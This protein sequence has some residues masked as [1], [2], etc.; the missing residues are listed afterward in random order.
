MFRVLVVASI[1]SGFFPT[2]LFAQGGAMSVRGLETSGEGTAAWNASG[3]GPEPAATGHPVSWTSCVQNA[4]HYLATRDYVDAAASYGVRGLSIDA[5]FPLFSAALSAGGYTIADLTIAHGLLSLDDDIEGED[6]IYDAGTTLETRY[7][8]GSTTMQLFLG[9]E[10][11]ATASLTEIT[12]FIDY[13]TLS[14]CF[15]DQIFGFSEFVLP[16]DASAGSSAA[17]QNAAAA[18]IADVAEY[19]VRF[20]FDSIQP[21]AQLDFAGEG[22]SGAFFDVQGTYEQSDTPLPVEL[23]AFDALADGDAVSLRWATASETNNAGFEVQQWQAT[24]W[25]PLAWVGGYGTTIEPQSYGLMIP[26]L[27]PDQY[28]FRLKQIDFDGTFSF[29][30]VV[31]VHVTPAA[32]ASVSVFPNPAAASATL[33]LQWSREEPLTVALYDVQGREVATVFSGNALP[34]LRLPLSLQHLPKGLYF[35]RA[36]SA[37][38]QQAIPLLHHE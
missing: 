6:W 12:V 27:A 20:D 7:Y 26:H 21:A 32:V 30:P 1:L 25:Q 15:D 36:T 38:T 22:R 9:G 35:L 3:V 2:L 13:N 31:E 17:V 18:F 33:T 14:N 24:R 11:M 16:E 29:S 37:T 23:V 4:F 28:H 19:G 10:L 34:S 5:G 8:T